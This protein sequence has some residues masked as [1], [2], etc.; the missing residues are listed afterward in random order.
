MAVLE[1]KLG[2]VTFI[3]K[4]EY[5]SSTTYERL[6]LVYHSGNSYVCLQTCAGVTPGTDN[7]YWMIMA[8]RGA[9]AWGEMSETEKSE[10]SSLL[11]NQIFGFK[12]TILTQ[13][14]WDNL[15]DRVDADTMYYI[16]E[17]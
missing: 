6:D 14:E 7:T 15:G 17:E 4:G 10:A 9:V 1:T 16:L 13:N 5:K 8:Q 3:P 2:R 12:P 11:G